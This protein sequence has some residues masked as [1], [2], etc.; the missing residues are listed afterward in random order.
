VTFSN[1]ISSVFQG[2]EGVFPIHN[3][4][5]C[6]PKIIV[7]FLVLD[8]FCL[9]VVIDFV[10]LNCFCVVFVLLCCCYVWQLCCW[11]CCLIKAYGMN[12]VFAYLPIF[13]IRATCTLGMGQQ[14]STGDHSYKSEVEVECRFGWR[15]TAHKKKNVP[16]FKVIL[17]QPHN[18][19][20]R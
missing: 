5:C 15:G 10:Y 1:E 7:L 19:V 2:L 8:L 18:I 3:S 14:D 13:L 20:S 17:P 9:R 6:L 16:E 11:G 4:Y 12:R